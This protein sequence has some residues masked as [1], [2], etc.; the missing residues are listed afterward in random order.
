VSVKRKYFGYT[1]NSI[2]TFKPIPSHRILECFRGWWW[3][4]A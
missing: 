2:P 1:G 4:Y 3:F